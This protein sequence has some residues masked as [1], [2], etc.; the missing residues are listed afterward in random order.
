MDVPGRRA[1]LVPP[2]GAICEG[3]PEGEE[4]QLP[5][6]TG[7]F[8]FIPFQ[9]V[10]SGLEH[11][12]LIKGKPALNDVVLIRIHSACATGDLFGSLRCD[13]GDQLDVALKMIADEKSGVLLYIQQEVFV[14]FHI[15]QVLKI[16][17]YH[18]LT[19][20]LCYTLQY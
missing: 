14:F 15:L 11:M 13:C 7:M 3:V 10:D 20:L 4:V 17:I 8:S 9:E 1:G 19:F 5:T 6:S 16:S 2:R 18:G 12:A